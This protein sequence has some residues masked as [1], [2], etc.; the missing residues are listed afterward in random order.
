MAVST[1]VFISDLPAEMDDDML[2]SVFGEYGNVTWSKMM[3]S[4]GK[5]T[6][7]GIVEF[8]TI[9]EAKWV[10]ENLDGN[11][12]QGLSTPINVKFKR[13]KI[14]KGDGKGS[15]GKATGKP[16]SA[17]GKG[18]YSPGYSSGYSS[19]SPGGKSSYGQTGKGGKGYS[20]Y[21]GA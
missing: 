13:P 14:I 9:E 17:P 10:V 18:G 3:P 6:Q 21:E 15:Y 4:K 8:A 16:F 2:A 12:A 20:P 19:Y 11:I 5:S 1:N 7:A